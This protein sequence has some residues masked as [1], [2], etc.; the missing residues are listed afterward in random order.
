MAGEQVPAEQE[1]PRLSDNAKW[2]GFNLFVAFV[3]INISVALFVALA[4]WRTQDCPNCKQFSPILLPIFIILATFLLFL[5]V[6]VLMSLCLRRTRSLTRTPQVVISSIPAEDL[7]KPPTPILP[8]NLGEQFVKG[9]SIDLPDYFTAV[10]S[11]GEVNFSVIAAVW[12]EGVSEIGPPCYEQALEV[13]ATSD[14]PEGGRESKQGDNEDN[15]LEGLR[16]G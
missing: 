16:G 2:L 11:I 5:G 4:V 1:T 12:A 15:R 7:E 6:S 9:S 10:R 14:S 8:Y 3:C 13:A